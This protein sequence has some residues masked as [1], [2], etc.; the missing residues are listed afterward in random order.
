MESKRRIGEKRTMQEIGQKA[1]IPVLA[2]SAYSL[3][4]TWERSLVALHSS[5]C[6]IKT[7]YDKPTDPPSK[8]CTMIMSVQDPLA[9][10]MIHL[11]FPGGPEELQE[12]VMEVCDGIKDHCV[13][14][15]NDPNDTRWEYT[16]HQRLFS[17]VVNGGVHDQIEMMAQKLAK[18]P[19]TRRAQAITWKVDEDNECYDPACFVAGSMVSTPNG[20]IEIEKIKDG[21]LIYAW[22]LEKGLMH[23]SVS[24]CFSKEEEC[25]E[26]ETLG[27]FK[28]EVSC[29]QKLLTENNWEEAK[30]IDESSHLFVPS[31]V[32]SFNVDDNILLGYFLGDGWLSSGFCGGERK[33]QRCVV[34]FGIHP[35]CDD[36]W[37]YEYLSKNT[38]NKINVF[39]NN[40]KSEMVPNGGIS[41]KIEVTDKILWEKL[42]KMGV[43]VGKKKNSDVMVKIE[44]EEEKKGF[45]TGIFSAEGSV[46]FNK[47]RPSIQL[48]MNWDQCVDFISSL[49]VEFGILHSVY[50]NNDTK[51]IQ[52]NSMSEI[53]KCFNVFD[54]RLDSRKQAKYLALKASIQ[55]S[56]SLLNERIDHINLLR[57]L[58]K[59]GAKQEEL[60]ELKPFNSRMLKEDYI[61]S[62]RFR[63]C[64]FELTDIGVY[65]PVISCNEI[66][67]KKV[68]DFE[69][70]H[71][72][73]A[74]VVNGIVSHNCL[75]SM[76]C[77]I[78]EDQGVWFLNTNVRFRSNDAYK[79][80]FMN[81]FALTMLQ[82][83]I[84]DRVAEIA[85][86]E[87]RLGRYVHIADSYH[88]YGSYFEEFENRFIKN[89]N[90]RKFEDRTAKFEDWQE[91]MEEAVPEILKK[92]EGM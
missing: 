76:W 21:D 78:L 33:I 34:S 71:P 5:G 87:V 84:A 54:F 74:M 2:V 12:Y 90:E 23:R 68:Y 9:E 52:I 18:S 25:L 32:S 24:N 64:S 46:V 19:Y 35:L 59:D 37:I 92:A 89:F 56:Y 20:L 28:T 85:G 62:F 61:P 3:A 40:I 58:Q 14:D 48:G 30:Y 91:M 77:R 26:I 82:K 63:Y 38:K 75:Q 65:L 7:Q 27:G 67:I 1:N 66:G 72:D 86:R 53:E 29:S 49:L 73:H 11:E 57:K 8:D 44:S 31:T 88:L 81:M 55:Y 36:S 17:Y 50:K 22:D 4:E 13:R 42:S 43:P 70:D 60:K 16:Y 69:V 41:K 80:A 51:I 6:D 79:A 83:K 45:L 47:L 10:P 39:E 15:P